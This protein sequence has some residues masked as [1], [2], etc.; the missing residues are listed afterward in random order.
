MVRALSAE[1]IPHQSRLI[2]W[3]MA[4]DM[5]AQHMLMI[6][7]MFLAG[8][9]TIRGH[10]CANAATMKAITA[11]RENACEKQFANAAG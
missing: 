3:R 11:T 9:M 8:A 5:F 1:N 6:H 7:L 2:A 10:A 4:P